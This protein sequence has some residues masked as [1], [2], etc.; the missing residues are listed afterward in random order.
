[1][2]RHEPRPGSTPALATVGR[3]PAPAIDL[4]AEADHARCGALKDH[5]YPACLS[6]ELTAGRPLART[7][8]GVPLVLFRD[9]Q[10]RPAALHD[11]CLHRNA[12]LSAGDVVDGN[13][14]CPYHGWVYA[15]DGRCLEIPSL[16]PEQRGGRLRDEAHLRAGLCVAPAEVGRVRSFATA[17]QDGLVFV[18][19]GAEARRPPFPTPHAGEPG[20]RVYYMVTRFPNGITNLV[21]NF[22]DVPHTV[23]VHRGW[24]RNRRRK[25]VPTHV[26]RTRDAVLVTYDQ[27]QDQIAGLGRLFNPGGAPMVHTDNFYAPH[28]TRVDYSFGERSGIAITSQCT[29]VSALDTMVYTAISFRL[30]LDLPGAL[31][32]RLLEPLVHWY[33]RQVIEQDVRIMRVQREGLVNSPGGGRFRGTAADLLHAHIETHRRWL[34]AGGAGEPPSEEEERLSFWI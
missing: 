13:I 31:L 15:G 12:A 18:L 3:E 23:V 14:A 25:E 33:T 32:G 21:E 10:G 26:R 29:P 24:F 28:V 20:W 7:I 19:P 11:R 9:P 22:M 16:G 27:R 5:W 30:P 34:L 17:E 6:R 2:S 4:D 1:M 8:F